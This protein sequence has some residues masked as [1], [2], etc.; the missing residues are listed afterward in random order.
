MEQAGG[1]IF[2]IFFPLILIFF[3]FYILVFLPQRK[4]ER[5]HKKMIDSLQ[6][7]DYVSTTAGMQGIIIEIKDD[8]VILKVVPSEVK[9]RFDKSAISAKLQNQPLKEKKRK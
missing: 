4:K 1:N 2:S 6:R 7:G 8:A 5:E 9:I 3:I